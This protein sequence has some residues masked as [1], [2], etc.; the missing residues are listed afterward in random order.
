LYTDDEDWF[1]AND[2]LARSTIDL[3]VTAADLV[4]SYSAWVTQLQFS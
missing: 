1:F 3:A 2:V 4:L